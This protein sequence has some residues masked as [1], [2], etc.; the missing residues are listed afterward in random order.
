MWDTEEVGSFHQEGEIFLGDS[1][2]YKPNSEEVYHNIDCASIS[3]DSLL[4]ERYD[5]VRDGSHGN[6]NDKLE[7]EE[8]RFLGFLRDESKGKT[9]V[10]KLLAPISSDWKSLM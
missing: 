4:P 8:D 2:N 1:E 7:E 5:T 9:Q 10:E 6:M 3:H